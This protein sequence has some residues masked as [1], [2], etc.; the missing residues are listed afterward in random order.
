MP[1]VTLM[2]GWGDMDFNAHMRNTAYLDKSADAR[3]LFFAANGFTNA[4]FRRAR[5]GP[6][7]MKDELEYYREVALLEQ[8]RVG[9]ELHGMSPDGSRFRLRNPFHKQDGTLSARVTST[10]GWLDLEQRKLARPPQELLAVM[11]LLERTA[12]FEELPSSLK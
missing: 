6:V 2:A 12:D 10:G 1:E 8:L 7:I 5:I 9:L 4:D 11:R 3:M